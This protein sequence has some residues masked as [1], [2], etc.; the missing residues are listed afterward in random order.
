MVISAK[1]K[2]SLNIG[3]RF[4]FAMVAFLFIYKQVFHSGDFILN[5]SIIAERFNDFGFRAGI[6][7][8]VVLMPLNWGLEAVKWKLLIGYV[9]KVNF[10]DSFRSVLTGISMSLFTP[11][12]VGEFFGRVFTLKLND[13]FKGVLLT[14]AGSIGQLIAT[15]LFGS[16]SMLVY[17]YSYTGYTEPWFGYLYAGIVFMV[18]L[19]CTLMVMLFLR[20]P[21]L[22]AGVHSMIRPGWKR[23]HE[24]ITVLQS[25]SR[26]TLLKVLLL[27][28]SRYIIFSSQFYIVLRVFDLSMPFG[29]A[30]VLIS[31]TYFVMTAI[32][33]VALVDLG[34]RGS[35]AIF[36][37]S[38]NFQ[39]K[40]FASSA[41]LY[42]TTLIWVINLAL[43]SLLGLLFINR[44]TIIRK[45]E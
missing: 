4:L 10:M 25:V 42:A 18:L 23:I 38:S 22:S 45:G 26:S 13:P 41:I 17:L 1:V 2:K 20:A 9:E 11:N 21:V 16:V 36:F 44:L 35:V 29:E 39:D 12:R 14:I 28:L 15:M 34:I 19:M 40:A 5:S 6:L 7:T 32:P 8:V 27:S 33:T 24:Y 31:M 3:L 37:L 43:P 30:F